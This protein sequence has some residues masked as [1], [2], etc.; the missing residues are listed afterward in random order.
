MPRSLPDELF[1]V[2]DGGDD[3]SGAKPAPP[4]GPES[5]LP[6]LRQGARL[7]GTTLVA[8]ALTAALI[9]YVIARVMTFGLFGSEA[10]SVPT[11][12]RPSLPESPV[13]L[14]P[15]EGPVTL[16]TVAGAIGECSTGGSAFNA[17]NL[18]DDNP[19]TIWRCAGDGEG[20][21]AVFTLDGGQ[22]IVGMR[23]VN[24]NTVWA[25]RYTQERRLV[26]IRWEFSDGSFVD[27]G[28][29]ANDPNPQEIRLPGVDTA[30]VRMT[31][32]ASTA[33]GA[34]G[35]PYDAVSIS[36]LEFLTPG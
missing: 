6:Q 7:S 28:L 36:S 31:V 32:V 11:S 24:G 4:S 33:Q 15:Y 14:V 34:E 23:V 35:L 29:A 9:G 21:S 18:S 22:P 2:D 26:R 17:G 20:E 3:P 13:I 8:A 30:W 12:S 5:I 19:E 10:D 16:A 25:D 1:R 27:Q